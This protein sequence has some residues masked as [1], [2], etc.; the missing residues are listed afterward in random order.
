MYVC[1]ICGKD[2]TMKD[3]GWLDKFQEGGELDKYI[4]TKVP[5]T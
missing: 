2:N 4:A 3:G 1:H 5:K